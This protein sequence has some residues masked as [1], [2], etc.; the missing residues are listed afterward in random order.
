M[1]GEAIAKLRNRRKK[2]QENSLLEVLMA[3]APFAH[4]S[5]DFCNHFGVRIYPKPV[6]RP[7]PQPYALPEHELHARSDADNSCLKPQLS[8]QVAGLGVPG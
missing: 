8:C 3:L 1:D 4:L 2:S 5:S 6:R 7:A